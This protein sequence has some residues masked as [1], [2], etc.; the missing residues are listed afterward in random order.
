MTYEAKVHRYN[1]DVSCFTYG[2][3]VYLDIQIK[4][5]SIFRKCDLMTQEGI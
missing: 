5:A 1:A 2:R 4:K 3:P